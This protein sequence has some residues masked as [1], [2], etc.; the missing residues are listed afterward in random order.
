MPDWAEHVRPRLASLRLLPAREAEIVE[1]L[2]Q[3][4]DDRW[5]ELTASG[6]SPEEA[7]RLTLA[8]FAGGDALARHLAPLRQAHPPVPIAP[9][10]PKGHV[11]SDLRQDLQY[12]A[13]TLRKRAGFTVTAVLTLALGI[14]ANAAIFTL[15]HGVLLRPLPYPNSDQLLAVYTRYL[16][17]TGYDFPYFSL[18]GPEFSD[19]RSRVT[20][21]A[22]TAAYTFANRNLT[23]PDGSAERVLTMRVTPGF[24]DVLGVNALR[25]RTFTEQEAQRGQPCVA[26]LA[27]DGSSTPASALASVLRLDDAPCQVIGFMPPGFAFRDDR[28]RVWTALPVDASESSINRQSHNLTAVARLREGVS[29]EQAEAQMQSLRG[30]WSE[31]FPDHYAKGHFAV[32]RPLHEDLVGSQRDA[33]LLL[34]GAV[35]FVLLIVCVNLA[36]L[37][38]SNGEAR[39]R[40][41]AV[42]YAL[43]ASRPRLIRQLVAEAMLLSVA[44]G[45]MGILLAKTLLAGLLALY[46]QRLPVVQ[47]ITI[48]SA[49]VI[50]TSALVVIAGLLIGL[51]PGLIATGARIEQTMRSESRTA[52][53][54]R[55]AV[56]ARSVLVTAQLAL[57]V[58]LLAGALLLIRSYERLQSVDLGITPGRVLTFNVFIP[59]GRQRDAAAA[60]RTIS[61]IADRLASMPGV[62]TAGAISNLPLLS[63]GSPDDF[64]IEGRAKPPAGAPAWN[65]RYLMATPSM[66]QALGIPLKRGRLLA[67]EDVPSQPLVAV[68]NEAAARLFWPDDDPIGR[69]I[70]YYPQETNPP[71][72]IVGIV[73]DVRSINAS[74]PPP[75]A[76][77][78]PL[79]Q[80][81]RTPYEGRAMSFVVRARGGPA[82]VAGAARAAV[83][84]IDAGLPVANLRP[85]AEVVSAAAG[86]PRFNTLVMSFFAG[87]AF[88]LAA[89]GLYGIL[90]YSVEQRFREIGVRVAL[91]A[92]RR[93][94]FRLIIGNGVG[95]ALIG[96]GAGVPAALLL[97]RLM[98]GLLS[99]MSTADPVTYAAVAVTLVISAILASYLPARRA[100]RVDPIAAL[101]SE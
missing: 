86:Q 72:R 76:V 66:F 48:D 10:A 75:P 24:F 8:E 4:L 12:A 80:A 90:A 35:V 22:R 7:T 87:V 79:A 5:R 61:A 63:P 39:R 93:E 47:P 9:G 100:T 21:F 60:R 64:V 42:R 85:M 1:E 65:A 33:L 15:I 25:G 3:H 70:R 14:G 34:G 84:S 82:S 101:R 69:T 46:P 49:A 45:G 31:K 78:V 11:F 6:T 94:I 98:S 68:I 99:G 38:I 41:F 32:S 83:N 92:G 50:Y 81:P 58:I 97:T 52:V 56:A 91:G 89:L 30:Y 26:V 96:I 53:S 57:S 18:S 20:A 2:S 95:L 23:H 74:E 55:R 77:Y 67:E 37:L 71:I 29:A 43:G 73:G 28:V 62:E 59:P 36:A 44:G 16:P 51:V 27:D 40:E 13:R 19:L 54:S 88:F 17:A